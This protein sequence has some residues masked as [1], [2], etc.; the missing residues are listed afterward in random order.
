MIT[1]MAVTTINS[2]AMSIMSNMVKD[3]L[4]DIGWESSDSDRI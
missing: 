4:L 2:R 1:H 3:V